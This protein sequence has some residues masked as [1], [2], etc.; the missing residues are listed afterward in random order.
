MEGFTQSP[1][2]LC[3]IPVVAAGAHQKRK[4][5]ERGSPKHV[6]NP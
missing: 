6:P 1:L 4:K 3:T 5:G 2:P